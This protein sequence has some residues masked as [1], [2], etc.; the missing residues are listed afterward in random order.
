MLYIYVYVFE[1]SW[2]V[3]V[4][5]LIQSRW[6]VDQSCVV[7]KSWSAK[8]AWLAV[9]F[10]YLNTNPTGSTIFRILLNNLLPLFLEG[11]LLEVGL[12]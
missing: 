10:H 4:G 9:G 7:S 5:V 2:S 11:T 3:Q 6:H 12:K 8:S 1:G